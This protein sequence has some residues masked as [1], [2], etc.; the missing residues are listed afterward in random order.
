MAAIDYFLKLDGINGE[1]AD[2][3]HKGEIEVPSF[4]FAESQVASPDRVAGGGGA[5]R[6]EMSDFS[7]TANTSKASPQLFLHCAQGK[8][9]KQAILTVRKAGQAQQ[10]YLKIKLNDVLVSSYALDGEAGNAAGRVLAQLRQA[11]L[12]LRAAEERR[13]PRRPGPRRLGP[14]QE[15]QDLKPPPSPP[16]AG[17]AAQLRQALA[18]RATPAPGS[19]GACTRAASRSSRTSTWR[20]TGAGS[21]RTGS[22]S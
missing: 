3:K 11:L 17:S 13:L 9:I 4:S 5:G 18:R 12:R 15:R 6:V 21:S 1:S 16:A 8:H 7:F 19:R 2:A 14:V 20:S 22:R 10:E